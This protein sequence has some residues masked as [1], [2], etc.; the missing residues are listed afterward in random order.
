MN[1]PDGECDVTGHAH[2]DP[3][4]ITFLAHEVPILWLPSNELYIHVNGPR[5]R[6]KP[7]R[8]YPYSDLSK[9]VVLPDGQP[10]SRPEDLVNVWGVAAASVESSLRVGTESVLTGTLKAEGGFTWSREIRLGSRN[11]WN[12]TDCARGESR[13]RHR[14]LFHFDY[15]VEVRRSR[16][17]FRAVRGNVVVGIDLESNRLGTTKLRRNVK[18][19][20]PNAHRRGQPAPWLL[21]VPFGG[22]GDDVLE[23]RFRIERP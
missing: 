14:A 19:L 15:G 1:I 13:K 17:G 11:E 18:W 16:S 7:A 22:S 20:R 5:H 12:L 21:E 9:S 2:D 10:R 23:T 4:A 3:L 8:G 6:G